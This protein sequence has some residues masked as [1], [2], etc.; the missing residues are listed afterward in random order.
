MAKIDV[1]TIEGYDTMSIEDKVAA[2]E[3]FEFN[4]NAEELAKQKNAVSK[5][6]SEAAEY[7]RKMREVEAK[8]KEGLTSSEQKIAELEA[9]IAEINKNKDIADYTAKFIGLGFE[10]ELAAETAAALV[11]KDT[12]TLF[13][14]YASQMQTHDKKLKAG[15]L[16]DTPK[17][18]I[19][20]KGTADS[21]MT[22][23]KFRKL[24]PSERAEYSVKHPDEYKK[25]YER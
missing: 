25:L 19:G 16:K 12:D 1:S 3:G 4:D 17:P 5:A 21:T 23:E 7:K 14:N 8:S 20:G 11:N 9:Q 10:S 2:L 22:L 24:S 6:N 13:K 15:L 18:D